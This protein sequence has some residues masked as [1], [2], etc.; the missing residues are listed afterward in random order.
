MP[1]SNTPTGVNSRPT[2]AQEVARKRAASSS[3][4]TQVAAAQIHWA[5]EHAKAITGFIV[6]LLICGAAYMAMGFFAKRQER[7]ATEEFY[8]VA[9]K[10]HKAKEEYDQAK[11]RDAAPK[12]EKVPDGKVATGDL[13]K[14]YGTIVSDLEKIARDRAGTSAGAEAGIL[15]GDTYLQY[16][17]PDKAV[18]LARLNIDKL[19]DGQTLKHLSSML[20]GNALATKGDCQEAVSVWQKVLDNSKAAYLHGDASLRAGLCYEQLGQTDKA[21]EMYRKA[22]S[23]ESGAASTARGLLRALEV[24][25]K[26]GGTPETKG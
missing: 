22:S 4:T 1:N 21:L 6:F 12:G 5:E 14:D 2:P 24:K 7:A 15:A 20:L 11:Y 17:Q 13:Q 8:S 18:E 26:S 3:T 16:K 10:F 19:S 25:A 9:A 23:T